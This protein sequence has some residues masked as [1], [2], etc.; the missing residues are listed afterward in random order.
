MDLRKL[1][2]EHSFLF[3]DEAHSL[4]NATSM[5]E[6]EIQLEDIQRAKTQMLAMMNEGFVP[7]HVDVKMAKAIPGTLDG[8]ASLFHKYLEAPGPAHKDKAA[9]KIDLSKL[10]E[11]LVAE[12]I[13]A[14]FYNLRRYS[15]EIGN[16]RTYMQ[17]RKSSARITDPLYDIVQFLNALGDNALEIF[18]Q[19]KG[20]ALKLVDPARILYILRQAGN[21]MLMSGTMQDADYI[22][23]V[24]SIGRS[25]IEV[26]RLDLEYREDYEK[27]FPRANKQFVLD[28]NS[29]SRFASRDESTWQRYA[30]LI[31]K[32]FALR[33]KSALVMS[34]SYKIAKAISENL[35]SPFI[36]EERHTSHAEVL[37]RVR[38]N[39][40]V[41]LAVANGKLM[42]GVE[43][44]D[45]RDNSSLVDMI[46]IC[47]IPYGVPDEYDDFRADTIMK[48]LGYTDKTARQLYKFKKFQYFLL[49]PAIITVRQAIGRA[50]RNPG[51]KAT[52]IL[53]DSRYRDS[54]WKREL[55]I[56]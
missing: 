49:Q 6:Q 26:I 43:F 45:Y 20:L 8:L 56:T 53:A 51:D 39:R 37:E 52:L 29:T 35:I 22:R 15:E 18:S 30:Q 47:G 55:G 28:L 14:G 50:I 46:M 32:N 17:K 48:R 23:K 9:F 5:F 40:C 42:E 25:E 7:P 3:I 44:V 4:E 36:L 27:V 12:D 38:R 33:K 19:G 31:D 34:P 41:I 10:D 54:P 11:K 16:L 24:W 2:L 13:Q 21:L 1:K